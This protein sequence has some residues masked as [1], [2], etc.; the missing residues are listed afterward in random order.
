MSGFSFSVSKKVN[1]EQ[2][3][4]DS[5]KTD[6]TESRVT[7]AGLF[8]KTKSYSCCQATTQKMPSQNNLSLQSQPKLYSKV[9]L[10]AAFRTSRLVVLKII[11]FQRHFIEKCYHDTNCEVWMTLG[12]KHEHQI[13]EVTSTFLPLCCFSGSNVIK[14]ER[15]KFK[16]GQAVKDTT[17]FV[18]LSDPDPEI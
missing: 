6:S 7:Q 2:K 4:F 11:C 15:K 16:G 17:C 10:T 8:L 12:S 1:E 18:L 3:L 9:F 5:P 13:E 14:Q